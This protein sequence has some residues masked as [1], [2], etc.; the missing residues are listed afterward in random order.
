MKTFFYLLAIFMPPLVPLL[1]GYPLRHT[2]WNIIL[3]SLLWVPGTAHAAL[4]VW[5]HFEYDRAPHMGFFVGYDV[6]E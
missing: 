2:V 1:L 6:N 5:G 4:L 3:T